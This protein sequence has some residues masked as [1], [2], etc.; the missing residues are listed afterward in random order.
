MAIGS[1]RLVER[2]SI[3]AGSA[4]QPQYCA[5]S[6]CWG[7][8]EDSDFQTKTTTK[9]LSH[10]LRNLDFDALSPVLK[11]AVKA[12]RSL[13]IPYLWVDSLC[14]L[15]DDIADWQRQCT[16]MNEIYG[17]AR[18][19]L[20]A[21]SS[22]T[23]REGFLNPK[24]HGL[25]L[26]YQSA[27]C[28]DISGSFMIYFT[29]AFGLTRSS[30][31]SKLPTDLHNDLNYSQWARRGWTFQEDAMA[32]ARIVFGAHD[33][34]FGKPNMYCRLY[35]SRAGTL[36]YVDEKPVT[37]LQ[38]LERKGDLHRAWQNVIRR[39]SA[40][41]ASSFTKQT[42][43]LPALSGL[44]R[45]FGNILQVKYVAGHWVD[46]LHVSLLWWRGHD[47]M[48]PA[49]LDE[50]TKRFGKKQYVI[51]SWSC[52]TRGRTKFPVS[53]DNRRCRSEINILD[54]YMP[55]IGADPY[56]ALQDCCLTL[57]GLLL[58]LPS[59][60]WSEQLD[61]PSVSW[62]EQPETAEWVGYVDS[63]SGMIRLEEIITMPT[64]SWCTNL[65]ISD[66]MASHVYHLML[67]FPIEPGNGSLPRRPGGPF[68]Q[69]VSRATLLLVA[70]TITYANGVPSDIREGYGLLLVPIEGGAL[71]SFLRVGI[72]FAA[73]GT[74]PYLKQLM[75]KEKIRIF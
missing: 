14:I 56:G 16:Q 50:I 52:L 35:V 70:S 46:M 18:V 66:P 58:D 72:F 19:T 25:R 22:R 51:P 68:G 74:L 36:G 29:H 10:H 38:I 49:S 54:V 47:D 73:K 23:C 21:A 5:L 45:I 61:V 53:Y 34:Y 67:D 59:V 28:P 39:Y 65:V 7:S 31:N 27:L 12:T 69:L 17:K 71:R 4:K 15:Q 40:F 33:V 64:Q 55:T 8:R 37:S 60:S 41:N 13:A 32:G 6:Y 26:P 48:P 44:A 11:D 30:P 42:D 43:V 20:I 57:E 62:S 24:R 2:Y 1:L 75:K 63:Q 9:N 3:S